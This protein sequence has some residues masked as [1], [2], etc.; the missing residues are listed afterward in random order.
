MCIMCLHAHARDTESDEWDDLHGNVL[1][2]ILSSVC[3]Q[4]V[5]FIAHLLF[6]L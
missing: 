6:L 3:M 2:M 1:P 5:L 4:P